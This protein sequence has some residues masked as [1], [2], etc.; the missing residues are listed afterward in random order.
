MAEL[1]KLET[2]HLVPRMVAG[3][4]INSLINVAAIGIIATNVGSLTRGFEQVIE[5]S[6]RQ[7]SRLGSSQLGSELKTIPHCIKTTIKRPPSIFV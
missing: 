3:F 1:V 5:F 7:Q 6:C 4:I 2:R